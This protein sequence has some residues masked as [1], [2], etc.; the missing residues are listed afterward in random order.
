MHMHSIIGMTPHIKSWINLFRAHRLARANVDTGM[1]AAKLPPMEWYDILLE[2]DHAG[3]AGLRPKE[4]E[5]SLL[6][7]QHGVSRALDRMENDGLI[8]RQRDQHDKR[9][10]RFHITPAGYELRA[11]IWRV[12][13]PVIAASMNENLSIAEAT[14]LASLLEKI[15][16]PDQSA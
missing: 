9:G 10:F 3:A 15:A 12:Y 1:K 11:Q 8:V 2:L 4:L 6:L 13:E 5:K 7:P 16:R 14:T